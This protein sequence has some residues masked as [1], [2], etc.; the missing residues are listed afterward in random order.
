MCV[1]QIFCVSPELLMDQYRTLAEDVFLSGI[2]VGMVGCHENIQ[3]IKDIL[4]ENPDISRV[5]DPVFKS[6]SGTWL[7]KKESIPEYISEIRGKSSLLTPNMEEAGMIS[8]IKIKNIEDMKKAAKRIYSLSST[9]CFIKGGHF[10]KQIANV[11]YDGIK[12]H[13]FQK[14]KL[15]KNVHGTGCFLSSSLLA[16]LAKG[17]N[18][19]EACLHSTQLTHDAIKSSVRIGRGQHIFSF[20]K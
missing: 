20:E 5:V 8:G 18:L 16:F 12:F 9:P 10:Q 4:E 13:L 11:L 6:S 1:K 7:L 17:K 14:E 3:I 2:K 15:N 19:E